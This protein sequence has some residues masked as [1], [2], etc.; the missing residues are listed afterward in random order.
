MVAGIPNATRDK[1]PQWALTF[2][3]DAYFVVGDVSLV[4]ASHMAKPRIN[5]GGD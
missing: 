2:Y 4:E 1:E 3:S 5:A